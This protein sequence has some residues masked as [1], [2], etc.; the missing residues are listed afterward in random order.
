MIASNKIV[1]GIASSLIAIVISF[2]LGGL[3]IACI[4]KDPFI[5]YSQFLSDTLGTPYGIGQVLFKATPLI[6]TGLSAAIAFRAGLFNIGA[7][8][9]FIV[10]A[11]CIAIAGHFFSTF[12][13]V[14]L[15]PVCLFAGFLGGACWGGIPGILKSVFG[16]HEVINTIMMNFIAAALVNY[17][18]SNIFFVPATVHTPDI[19]PSAFLPRLDF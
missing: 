14:I 8:G 13:A 7:E 2:I 10:G 6:L 5:V 12:P 9:Q 16:A 19:A 15:I 4:G 1:Q 18:V 11:F 17:L 3:F